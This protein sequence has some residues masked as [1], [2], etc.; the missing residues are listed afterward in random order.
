M[1]PT[2]PSSP[3][4]SSGDAQPQEIEVL[5]QRFD[6][7]ST[8]RTRAETQLEGARQELERLKAQAREAYG[9]D[10]LD[11]LKQKLEAMREDNQ[12]KRAQ[13]QQALDKIEQDLQVIEAEYQ[14]S[15][16]P[17]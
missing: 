17:S 4:A 8:Q 3:D 10:N 15:I 12:N 6:R 9:T 11:E 1:T 7:L 13:Y 14:Q 2:P 5:K 16:K